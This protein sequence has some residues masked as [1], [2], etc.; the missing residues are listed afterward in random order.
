M[1]ASTL[2]R[3]VDNLWALGGDL[4]EQ[5][6]MTDPPEPIRLIETIDEE[7][8][9]PQLGSECEDDQ[10]SFDATCRKLRAF[11]SGNP[12]PRSRRPRK[13][14]ATDTKKLDRLIAEA[15]TDAYDEDEQVGGFL[16]CLEEHVAVPFAT[17]LL[18][19]HVQVTE[20]NAG[21]D[22]RI[23]AECRRGRT[24][25]RIAVTDLPLPTPPPAGH[26]WIAAYRRWCRGGV[27]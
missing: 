20:F 15:T 25:Q 8:G 17:S 13:P 21:D 23:V 22:G 18:G 11:L 10:R 19:V 24:R 4:I 26:E 7:G 9:P 5:S 2:R 1:A 3:H 12:K 27:Y 14:A 16:C 6:R